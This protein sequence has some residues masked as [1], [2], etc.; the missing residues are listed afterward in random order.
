VEHNS[1]SYLLFI[2]FD[3][4][5]QVFPKEYVSEFTDVGLCWGMSSSYF[6]AQGL[7]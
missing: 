5:G 3:Y 2:D 7:Y 6:K 4:T 1:I